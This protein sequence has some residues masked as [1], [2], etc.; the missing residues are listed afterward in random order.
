MKIRICLELLSKKIVIGGSLVFVS[1]SVN[2][3]KANKDEDNRRRFDSLYFETAVNISAR[4]INR[5]IEISDSLY[6]HS[7]QDIHRLKALML[8]SSLSQQ[9]G[10]IRK[11]VHYAETA[12]KIAVKNKFY[13]W[14][15]RIAGFLS[16]QY[17]LMGLYDQGK[18]Y[19]EKGQR[20][21]E[22]IE[23][24]QIRKLYL[25]LIYQ[26]TAYYE[27]EYDN[28][29]KAYKSIARAEGYFKLISD[30][31]NKNYFFA[32]N[33]ELFGRT[34]IGLKEW[35]EALSHYNSAI[36]RLKKVTQQDAMINGF[37]YS[38]LGRVYLEKK[39]Y[40]Q[41]FENLQKAEQIVEQSD[42]LELKIEVYKTLSEY[43][44]QADD[45]GNYS[46]YNDKYI[47]AFQLNEKNKKQ[48][49]DS[50]V[51]SIQLR[52]KSLSYNRNVFIAISISLFVFIILTLIWHRRS[53][54]RDFERFKL[55]MNRIRD[56]LK[57]DASL[58]EVPEKTESKD[59]KRLMSEVV[60]V[61]LLSDL[62]EFEKSEKYT[63]KQISLPIL[64][65]ILNTNT[66]YLSH[67]LNTH[68][69]KDFNTY[70][71]ELRVKYIIEEIEK[72]E[73]FKNYKISYLAEKAG[74]SSHSKFSA[75][76]KSVTGFSPSTFLEYL[77]KSK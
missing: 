70:I 50:F 26:E 68:K 1:L 18:V 39:A 55:I 23:N 19:L 75:I 3:V 48:S 66:K 37:V 63:D 27:I 46:I 51:N 4:D 77:E 58:T 47:D 61:K 31:V 53:K 2:D 67:V 20:V 64:A 41:A 71:N 35:D 13:D 21:S 30:E 28:Y 34:C 9:K 8:T 52:D 17:R 12:D 16:T 56:G 5:A 54:K 24:D 69:N 73:A 10:D 11:S 43:Y 42:H 65:G 45:Y 59:K 14:E 7:T 22:H 57:T 72:N 38:G 49:I 62:D 74:F 33:E 15:A 40:Q 29:D 6:R 60:E 32:T 36:E 25:G 44:K 76:F